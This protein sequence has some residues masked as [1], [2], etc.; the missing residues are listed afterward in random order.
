MKGPWEI[1]RNCGNRFHIPGKKDARVLVLW[2][3]LIYKRH[4][5]S[6]KHIKKYQQQLK[7][8]KCFKREG[9][10]VGEGGGINI[11]IHSFLFSNRHPFTMYY[12][13]TKS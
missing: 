10:R 2:L 12:L 9:G 6:V 7:K 11:I 4:V 8:K 5:Y 3:L 13:E 1:L